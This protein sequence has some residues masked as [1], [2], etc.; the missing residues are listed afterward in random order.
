M[1]VAVG[2]AG[3]AAGAAAAGAGAAEAG[4][5]AAE[6]GAGAGTVAGAAGLGASCGVG[7]V[8]AGTVPLPF[9]GAVVALVLAPQPMAP[10]L[11]CAR[12][13][14]VPSRLQRSNGF[15]MSN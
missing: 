11:P 8:R 15:E 3:F 4:A 6:A 2:A 7:A 14:L 10:R 5:G 9:A 12:P 1:A 13:S